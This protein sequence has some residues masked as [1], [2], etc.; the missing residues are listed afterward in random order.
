MPSVVRMASVPLVVPLLFACSVV[1]ETAPAQQPP[2]RETATA[3]AVEPLLIEAEAFQVNSPGWQPRLWGTNYYAATFGDTFLSRKAYLAA[4]SQG[5]DTVATTEIQVTQAGRHLALV[6]YEAAPRFETRF[7]LQIVQ[8]NRTVLNREYG[9]RENVKIWPFRQGLQAE[10]AAESTANE[11][12]VWEGHDAWVELQPGRATLRLIAGPQPEPAARRHVD[13]VVLT[14]DA[15]DV[16][17]R[18]AKENYLPLDGLLTQAGDLFLRVRNHDDGSA[19]SVQVPPGTEHS[20]YWV[21]LR[22]WKPL[23][24]SA[25]AGQTT[26]WAEVGSLLDTLN[27][28][29]WLLS[30]ESKGPLHYTVEFA[31][32]GPQG[33][34]PIGSFESREKTLALAYDADTRSTRRVR[35][36]EDVLVDLVNLLK[37]HPVS[38]RP[39]VRTPIYAM[40]FE[41]RPDEPRY[42]AAREEFLRLLPVS[43]P[44][45]S[46]PGEPTHPRGFLDVRRLDDEKL[47]ALLKELR[48]KGVAKKVA[49]VS[50]GNPLSLP[51]PPAND[52]HGFQEWVKTRVLKAATLDAAAGDDWSKLRYA[53]DAE[54]VRKNPPL[55]F[56]SRRYAYS[57]G[58]DELKRRTDLI[59]RYLPNAGVG[60]VFS[61][62]QGVPYLGATHQWTRLF[63]QQGL[64]MP[65]S[66]DFL[67][68]APLG[69]QQMNFLNVDLFRAALRDHPAARIQSN[70]MPNSPGNTPKSWRR[71]FFGDLAHGVKILNLGEL[72]PVQFAG[73]EHYV[74]SPEMYLEIR[75]ALYELG[76]FEDLAQDGQ[77][78]SGQAALWFS[79]T[80]DVW[81]DDEP[82]FG[83]EKRALY[84]A[85]RHQ[86]L[87]L[88]V[89]TAR[90]GLAMDLKNYR[91][92]YL[93]G[94]H[95]S[96][97]A[98]RTV[99]EWV[100][101]GGRLVAT[102][103]AGLWNEFDQPN[104]AMME[105]FGIQSVTVDAPQSQQVRLIKQ[106]LPFVEPLE[107]VEV[108]DETQRIEFPVFGAITRLTTTAEEV[109][110]RF[111]DGS[112]ALT[113]RRVGMGQA[114]YCGFLPGLSYFKPAIPRRPVDRGATDDSMAHFLPTQFDQGAAAVIG[115][116]AA[117]LP[118]P[119]T[120]SE[121]L[122][123]ATVIQA[124]K[125]TVIPLINWSAGP[126]RQLEVRIRIDLPTAT[127][128]RASG[129]PVE[130]VA[131]GNERVFRLDLDVA[132]ALILRP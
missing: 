73:T 112:P 101:N 48:D 71:Q 84:V 100:R 7:R 10:P 6:R 36:Q 79:E 19:L 24:I 28:G 127:V 96:K 65:W 14:T 70:I 110:G 55:Y 67:W 46:Q 108:E 93:T 30:V 38:G 114:V 109:A 130:T 34:V 61:P 60:A 33:P 119:V 9:G 87:P 120:C 116:V 124:A 26:D 21:H 102:A 68:T 81:Q 106:D 63:D 128:T 107:R 66:E 104:T 82:P 122:V 77:V 62:M 74:N 80:G 42:A 45:L 64:T 126:V 113:I 56:F 88:D 41:P 40:T 90:D 59:L 54:T 17:E 115:R 58:I 75:R 39:P 86:Q 83:A 16:Q 12:I 15:A 50:L 95:I 121:P 37:R 3:S 52:H 25:A 118:R 44:D 123:E 1:A 27:D 5:A 89:V 51:E 20:P 18:L 43:P 132:D 29:Q 97:S 94:R 131:Q 31:V 8:N 76:E 57:Y 98:A 72:R 99:I 92:L 53:P 49:V 2:R 105:L 13:A 85:V 91:V 35:R 69:S 125:G 4:S 103:E 129:E 22:R 47:E 11:N 78:T 111:S 32:P 23:T 117:D